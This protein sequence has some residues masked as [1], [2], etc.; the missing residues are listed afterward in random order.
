M[1]TLSVIGNNLTG[2]NVMTS[3]VINLAGTTG[4]AIILANQN[5]SN[6]SGS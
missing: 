1:S 3:K 5:N 4:G 6:G 2:A